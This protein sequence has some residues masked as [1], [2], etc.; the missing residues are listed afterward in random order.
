M[1]LGVAQEFGGCGGRDIIDDWPGSLRRSCSHL[2][3]LYPTFEA[4]L[5]PGLD[6]SRAAGAVTCAPRCTGQSAIF[7]GAGVDGRPKS[8]SDD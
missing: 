5:I 6:M 1:L 7:D 2:S 4:H 8:L 3:D